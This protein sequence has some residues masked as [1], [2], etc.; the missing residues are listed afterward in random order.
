MFVEQF[1]K[2]LFK[3]DTGN[4]ISRKYEDKSWGELKALLKDCK[5][6]DIND[7]AKLADTSTSRRRGWR[8]DAR[9]AISGRSNSVS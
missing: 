8:T 3:S 6:F 4:A 9:R 7:E 5:R 2:E 1:V